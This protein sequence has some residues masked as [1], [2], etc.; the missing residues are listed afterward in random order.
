LKSDEIDQ[1]PAMKKFLDN[2][3]PKDVVMG[4]NQIFDDLKA[5]DILFQNPARAVEEISNEGMIVDDARLKAYRENPAQLEEDMRS[6]LYF[7]FVAFASAG[8]YL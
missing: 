7:S 6:G 8:G 5:L 2:S 3:T 4:L 1:D